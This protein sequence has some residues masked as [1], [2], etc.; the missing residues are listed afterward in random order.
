MIERLSHV[1]LLVDSQD[2][3]KRFYAD[4][5]GFEVH[6]D[7]DLGGWRWLA[8]APPGQSDIGIVLMP[9]D[10]YPK[11]DAAARATALHMLHGGMF[12][13]SVLRTGDCRKSYAE[14]TARG[15]EFLSPP[16]EFFFGIEA[17]FRDPFGNTFS[18][19]QPHAAH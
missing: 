9:I 6:S 15:V 12:P 16:Q 4:V 14:L 10:A 11:L 5:L 19:V 13:T 8:V 1:T 2:E 7:R 18:L 3:A 17:T